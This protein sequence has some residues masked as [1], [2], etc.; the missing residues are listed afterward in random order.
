MRFF[1]IPLKAEVEMTAALPQILKTKK[2]SKKK[3]KEFQIN[4]SFL[5][6]MAV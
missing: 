5:L 3:I 2:E 4:V 6:Y 1:H